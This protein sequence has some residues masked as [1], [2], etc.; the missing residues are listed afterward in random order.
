MFDC[1][2]FNIFLADPISAKIPKLL[3]DGISYIGG[4]IRG[5]PITRDTA[6]SSVERFTVLLNPAA[7]CIPDINPLS[8]KLLKLEA[9]CAAFAIVLTAVLILALIFANPGGIGT[10]L[11]TNAPMPAADDITPDAD[12]DAQLL[13]SATPYLLPIAI[14]APTSPLILDPINADTPAAVPAANP[15]DNPDN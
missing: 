10:K 4:L 2:R 11:P 8:E 5:D 15:V 3:I 14:N 9:N 13:A 6:A 1:T 7:G 12:P